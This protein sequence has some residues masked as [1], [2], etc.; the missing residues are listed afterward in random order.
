MIS[1]LIIIF[2]PLL[3]RYGFIGPNGSGKSS[4]LAVLGNRE[5]PIQE[6]IDIFYLSREM[7]ASEKS[8]LEAVKE[9]D[10]E[11]I[12]L[13]KLAE[14]LVAAEDEESQDYLMEIYERLDEIGAETAEAKASLLLKNLGFTKEMQAKKCKDFSGII[15]YF[16]SI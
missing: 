2:F 5:V 1:R 9:A 6:H 4:L 3:N 13:E 12:K 7:P 8:A 15:I 10:A 16:K 14:Q 11:R